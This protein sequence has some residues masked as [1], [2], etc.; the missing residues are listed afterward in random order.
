M[1][2]GE[3]FAKS[4]A[5]LV[6]GLTQAHLN[7]LLGLGAQ[8]ALDVETAHLARLALQ[9]MAVQ[10]AMHHELFHLLCGHLD[11][12][13]VAS[14]S[15]AL[16]LEELALS[17]RRRGRKGHAAS[18]AEAGLSMYRELEADA[19]ALQFLVDR[20][21]IGDLGQLIAQGAHGVRDKRALRL[22]LT[23]L[24]KRQRALGFRVVLASIWLVLMLFEGLREGHEGQATSI[25]HPWPAARAL[26]LLVT[27]LP[28]YCRMRGFREDSSG[29]RYAVLTKA[30]ALAATD[31]MNNVAKPAM[32]FAVALVDEEQLLSSF[33]NPQPTQSN[34]LADVLRDLKAML[35]GEPFSS[36]GGQQLRQLLEQRLTLQVLLSPY[37]Y[38]DRESDW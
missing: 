31:F 20:C 7:T 28:F 19:S 2:I 6:E 38:F 32:K 22:A 29:F 23:E 11:H 16:S 30:S 24:P 25:T 36:L 8:H 12:H 34:L 18:E 15:A 17:A 13:I 33:E 37:E 14:D 10:F 9:S 1:E 5:N 21:V 3:A 27:L 4:L 35:F 26:A